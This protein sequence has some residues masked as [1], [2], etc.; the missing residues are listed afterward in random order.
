MN[1]LLALASGVLFGLGLG[2]S[3]MIDPAKVLGFLDLSAHWDPTLAFVMGGAVLVAFPAFR[4]ARH[5][6]RPLLACG[7]DLPN[8]HHI[9][10]RLV[11]G[12]AVFGVGWGLAGFCP[13]PAIAA[14]ASFQWPVVGFVVAMA[15]GQWLADRLAADEVAAPTR[16]RSSA[17]P[18]SATAVPRAAVL[19]GKHAS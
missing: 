8:R 12:A 14:L 16:L 6:P 7:F 18:K 13:G 10:W 3:G 17:L 19:A 1:K 2:V 5:A 4:W 11:T 15:S 9:D